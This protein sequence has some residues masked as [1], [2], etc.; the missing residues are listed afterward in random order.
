MKKISV[1]FL[2]SLFFSFYSCEEEGSEFETWV[3]SLTWDEAQ[4]ILE[5]PSSAFMRDARTIPNLGVS[6]S[7]QD[8]V[9]ERGDVSPDVP[10]P[11]TLSEG[12]TAVFHKGTKI[13]EEAWG[14]PTYAGANMMTQVM[15]GELSGTSCLRITNQTEGDGGQS[16]R[17]EHRLFLDESGSLREI[18][19]KGMGVT[20][21]LWIGSATTMDGVLII[22]TADF[23]R[24]DNRQEHIILVEIATGQYRRMDKEV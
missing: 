5:S 16:S 4:E 6:F 17:L 1:F 10:Y 2:M 19:L 18:D 21:D 9:T 20:Y 24:T 7:Y 8:E 12:K 14:V 22:H 23:I 11:Y 3:L 15:Y 13:F